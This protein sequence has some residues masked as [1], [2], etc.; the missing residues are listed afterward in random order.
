MKDYFP[1][2][3]AELLLWINNFRNKFR[4]YGTDYG[5]LAAEIADLEQQCTAMEQSILDAAAQ[6]DM[7]AKSIAVKKAQKAIF[8]A[9]ARKSANRIKAHQNYTLGIGHELGIITPAMT[10]DKKSYKPVLSIKIVGRI[11]RV[12]YQKKG[13]DSVNIY[14]RRKGEV[15]WQLVARSTRSPYEHRIQLENPAIPEHWEY[16][17]VGVIK[18]EEIGQPSDIVEVIFGG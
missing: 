9:K 17:A 5:L 10:F 11:L 13:V 8:S 3:D 14:R 4:L 12:K 15:T 18:D 1:Y 16:R 2:K 6:K 7:L